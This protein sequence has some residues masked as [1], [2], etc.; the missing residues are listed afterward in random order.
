VKFFPVF[1]DLRERDCLVVGG[2]P[3]AARKAA[4]LLEAGARVTLV[5]P[6][7]GPDPGAARGGR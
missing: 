4:M 7:L 6:A 5:S 1:L 2:G 3:V